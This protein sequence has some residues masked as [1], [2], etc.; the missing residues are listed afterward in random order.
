MRKGDIINKLDYIQ[1]KTEEFMAILEKE[2]PEQDIAE[3]TRLVNQLD[4]F[5]K[6]GFWSRHV[7]DDYMEI[8]N[9][10]RS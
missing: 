4:T 1:A 7:D 8:R 6:W 5:L 10:T 3:Y 9:E 2:Y